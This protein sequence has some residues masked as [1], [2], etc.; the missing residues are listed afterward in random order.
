VVEELVRTGRDATAVE[1]DGS[2]VPEAAG[3]PRHETRILIAEDDPLTA[4]LVADRLQRR[5]YTVIHCTDGQEALE[6]ARHRSLALVIIDVTMPKMNGFELLGK[7]R[8]MR[9]HAETPVLMLTGMSDERSVI[10]AFDLG[11]NDYVLKPFS[12]TELTARVAR[13]IGE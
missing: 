12:P 10:R 3:S 9:R 13:L 7:L 11:A 8:D 2:A 1:P 6:A 4:D 5:G